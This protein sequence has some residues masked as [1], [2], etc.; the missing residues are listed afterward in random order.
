MLV[1]IAIALG[2]I[3]PSSPAAVGVFEAAVLVGLNPYDIAKP[4]AL[5]FAL[6]LHALNFF[7][8][9]AAGVLILAVRM[10]GLR[11]RAEAQAE[12]R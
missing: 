12:Q 10:R 1:T 7:P 4:E 5:S 11:V 6:V 3:L 9:I 2:M 8:Y